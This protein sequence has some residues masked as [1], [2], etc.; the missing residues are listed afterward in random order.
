MLLFVWETKENIYGYTCACTGLLKVVA[1]RRRN[2]WLGTG[3][4]EGW[5]FME[6][7]GTFETWY[8]FALSKSKN[9]T[10]AKER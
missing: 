10:P 9:V 4:K 8:V 5:P 2:G 6:Y 7:S 1:Y 3:F